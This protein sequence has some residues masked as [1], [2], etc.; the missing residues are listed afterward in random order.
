MQVNIISA[1]KRTSSF[2]IIG[3][4]VILLLL[5]VAGL[6]LFI[7]LPDAN[8]FNDR[9]E[10]IFI[11]NDALTTTESIKLLEVLAQSG[12]SFAEVLQSYRVIIFIL[13]L[14]TS[15]LLLSALFFLLTNYGLNRQMGELQRQGMV[16]TSL[17][18]NR[19]DRVVE[20]NDLEIELTA[21]IAETMAVLC[22][23]RLDDDVLSGAELEAMISGKSKELVD[24]ASGATRIKRLR[25]HL[26][27]QIVSQLLIKNLSRRGYMLAVDKDVIK[28]I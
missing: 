17:V 23:A 1:S 3:S 2:V 4:A 25:D 21:A 9:V 20:I 24:E 14:L 26:G 18:L 8:A 28:L 12:T 22:E 13:L 7:N 11:E 15:A 5:L 27:N 16:I 10:Q 19:E 6:L